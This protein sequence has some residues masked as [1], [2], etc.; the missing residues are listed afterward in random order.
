[1]KKVL[2]LLIATLLVVTFCTP[3]AAREESDVVLL[4]DAEKAF[5]SFSLDRNEMTE[6][7]ASISTKLSGESM[8]SSYTWKDTVDISGTDTIAI[9]LYVSDLDKVQA[10]ANVFF[11]ISSSG[12]CDKDELQW[13]FAGL[14]KDD[15]LEEGWNTVYLDI[16]VATQ[17]NQFDETA[18]NFIRF[19]TFHT[20]DANGL[21][22]KLDNIRAC[23]TGGE[24]Y[25]DMELKAYQGD[26]SDADIIIQGQSAPDLAK[27]D[28][29][30]TKVAGMK[31]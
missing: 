14:L 10:L 26:N 3:M 19:Y 1:M 11:E 29:G 20:T 12:T 15:R 5:G 30:I 17:A 25:S 21:V 27:R 16:G 13:E 22:I 8:V 4:F 24:D 6:G 7:D 9:D 2:T 23:V 18:V 31:K 28:E